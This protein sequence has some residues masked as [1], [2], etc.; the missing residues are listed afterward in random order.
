VIGAP[1][2]IAFTVSSSAITRIDVEAGKLERRRIAGFTAAVTVVFATGHQDRAAW[3]NK[4]KIIVSRK[5]L[6]GGDY[7]LGSPQHPCNMPLVCKADSDD[8]NFRSFCPRG[9][10]ARELG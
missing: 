9:Q 4:F 3:R 6:L 10:S 1:G 8:G 5:R 7:N 2:S